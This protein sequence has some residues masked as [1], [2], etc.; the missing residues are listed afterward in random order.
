[1]QQFSTKSIFS[2]GLFGLPMALVGLPIYVYAPQFY[3]ENLGLSLT[4]IGTA[5][6]I[7]RISDACIDPLIGQWIDQHKSR[8]GYDRFILISLPL[9]ALGFIG[10]FHPPVMRHATTVIWFVSTL[11]VVYTGFSIATIAYQSWGA[12]LTQAQ[13]ERSRLTATREG[14]GLIGLIA[15]ATL[16]AWLGFTWLIAVFVTTLCISAAVLLKYAPRAKSEMPSH[17]GI[18]AMTAPFRNR[19]FRYLFSVFVMN[20]IAAAIPATL[21]LFFVNDQLRLPQ[22]AGPFLILYFLAA[23]C[24]MPLWIRLARRHG[25]ARIWLFAMLLSALVFI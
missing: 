25:E 20:G 19:R 8:T 23:A 14:S 18:A 3:S 5:L 7:I 21:F 1:M 22:Y 11:L 17:Q 10:L 16:I 4:L 6:L 9:L 24:S 13:G 15:A 2:Y 12:A